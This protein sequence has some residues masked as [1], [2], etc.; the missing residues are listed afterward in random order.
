[1][2]TQKISKSNLKEIHDVA[3]SGW[4]EKIEK[5]ATRDIFSD[6]IELTQVEVDEMFEA[7]DEK[8]KNVLLKFLA[9]SKS[10][11]DEIKSFNDA[12]E[13]LGV[14]DSQKVIDKLLELPKSVN[15]KMIAL[16]KLEIIVKALNDGWTPN[17]SNTNEPKYYNWFNMDGF[18]CYISYFNYE[19]S[20][21]PSALCFKTSDLAKHCAKI[22]IKEYKELYN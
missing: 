8:Q 18:S 6:T 21:V 10:K 5:L 17:W 11:L 12:C 16:Y 19:N 13:I 1:M 9:K 15:R 20:N 2:N 7:S 4:K 22:A 3:C 14:K